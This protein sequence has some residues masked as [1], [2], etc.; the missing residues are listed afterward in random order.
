MQERQ[1][2]YTVTLEPAEEGGYVVSVPALPGCLTQGD[3][4]EDAVAM[5][6]DA[7]LCYLEGMMKIGKPIPVERERTAAVRIDVRLPALA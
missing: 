1:Y 7:I 5:A 2:S 4:Y 3:T 6:K